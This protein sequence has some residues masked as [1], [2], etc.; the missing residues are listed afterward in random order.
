MYADR[1]AH[2]SV[3]VFDTLGD[4]PA[5]TFRSSKRFHIN[6][7]NECHITGSSLF[8]KSL[9]GGYVLGGGRWIVFRQKELCRQCQRSHRVL[10]DKSRQGTEDGL[11]AFLEITT[12]SNT[13]LLQP[14]SLTPFGEGSIRKCRTNSV[15]SAENVAC[16]PKGA[17]RYICLNLS[18]WG[19][20]CPR[21]YVCIYRDCESVT[22]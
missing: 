7:A 13:S 18:P 11:E 8:Q 21:S 5:N 4:G 2:S 16:F 22:N 12:Y 15:P 1:T 17:E 20:L 9:S 6:T 14:F 3:D 19:L 10:I